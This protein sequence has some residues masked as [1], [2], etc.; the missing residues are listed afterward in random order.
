V[1]GDQAYL[2]VL[3]Y[4]SLDQDPHAEACIRTGYSCK[5]VP[6]LERGITETSKLLRVFWGLKGLDTKA[7]IRRRLQTSK[8]GMNWLFADLEGVE[9]RSDR[10]LPP[11]LMSMKWAISN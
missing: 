4:S 1:E 9:P 6:A 10:V 2:C 7:Q 3:P 5:S 11:A 8:L